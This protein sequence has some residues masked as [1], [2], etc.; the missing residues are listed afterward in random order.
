MNQ[1]S[2]E[3]RVAFEMM[4][5]G[6]EDALVMSKNITVQ[7]TDQT[8]MERTGDVLWTPQPYIVTSYN[9]RDMT[10]N[11]GPNYQIST[12]ISINYEQC[13]P[14]TMS[15]TELRDA[16]QE[17]RLGKAAYERLASDINI[18]VATVASNEGSI[19]VVKSTAAAGFADVAALEGAFNRVGVAQG[20]RFLALST[21]DYNGLAADL[22]NRETLTPKALTA[23]ERAYVGQVASFK[24][25]KL[26]YALAATDSSVTGL[27]IN[28]LAAG[29]NYYTPAATTT[30]SSGR[31]SNVDN[32][33]QTVTFSSNTGMAVGDA[34]TIAGVNEAHHIT[35][36]STGELKTFRVI[37]VLAANQV[38][39]TPPMVDPN[40]GGGRPA[41]Q[42][43]NVVI[44]ASGTAAITLLNIAAKPINPFWH[45]DAI[46]LLPGR[47]AVPSNSGMA[48]IRSRTSQGIEVT[49]SKQTT[50]NTLDTFYRLDVRY[51]VE[52]V[53]TEMAGI[54]LFS[55]T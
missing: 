35:K 20:D 34:F 4:L 32:R 41:E 54:A 21:A 18:A 27:T 47:Y 45:K 33:Y 15:P 40:I 37:E 36:L 17:E 52:M 6:F 39:I 31:R 2:K 23:Y 11:F 30:D 25:F 1:Y 43:Q 13:V 5:E 50:I 42:Y 44:T 38:V 48:V 51:G 29:G 14:W 16:L 22:A 55:Q 3:E 28:T 46:K 7:K 10:N 19:V 24:T 49:M 53:N 26:D 9:G 12:P 8:L